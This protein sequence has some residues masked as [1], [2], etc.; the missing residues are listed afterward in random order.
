MTTWMRT[1]LQHARWLALAALVF[2]LGLQPAR[3]A[4]VEPGQ[5]L[6]A[7]QL[8]D[9]HGQDW[10]VNADTRLVLFANGR[11]ASNLVQSVLGAQPKGFL[12]SRKAVYLADLSRMPSFITRTFALPALREQPFTVGVV[13]D[14][15]LLQGWPAAEDALML[16]ELDDGRVK[17]LRPVSSEAQLRA[18]LGL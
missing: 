13:L 9:Q 10:R 12:E 15:A 16:I 2:T 18:A 5:P 4:A 6:P 11:K 7:L 3:A 1:L 14:S 17:A 8:K